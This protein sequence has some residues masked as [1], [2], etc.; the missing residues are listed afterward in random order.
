MTDVRKQ[1]FCAF[2][3]GGFFSDDRESNFRKETESMVKQVLF[4][5][6]LASRVHHFRESERTELSEESWNAFRWNMGRTAIKW[7]TISERT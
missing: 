6:M 2:Y 1:P 7:L 5:D 3:R 4:G